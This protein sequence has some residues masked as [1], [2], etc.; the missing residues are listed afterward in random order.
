M[1]RNL[2][3][4]RAISYAYAKKER[5]RLEKIASDAGV[6]N[7]FKKQ[8]KYKTLRNFLK[9]GGGKNV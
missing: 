7:D 5:E 9:F 1:K 3:Q 2:K 8:T 4:L 6:L